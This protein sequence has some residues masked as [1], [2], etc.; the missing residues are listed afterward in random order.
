MTAIATAFVATK[1]GGRGGSAPEGPKHKRRM[2]EA[3]SFVSRCKAPGRRGGK[4]PGAAIAGQARLPFRRPLEEGRGAE[5]SDRQA[6]PSLST[7]GE[8]RLSLYGFPPDRCVGKHE[9][10]DILRCNLRAQMIPQCILAEAPEI[11]VEVSEA[12]RQCDGLDPD[13]TRPF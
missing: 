10:R 8:R 7:E 1:D 5:L 12:W 9:A 3:G 13:F 6:D 4:E 11:L 2:A